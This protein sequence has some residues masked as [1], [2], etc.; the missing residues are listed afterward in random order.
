MAYKPSPDPALDQEPFASMQRLHHASR[1]ALVEAEIV[2]TAVDEARERVEA[3][4]LTFR[5]VLAGGVESADWSATR[6]TATVMNG[7]VR[8][9]EVR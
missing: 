7:V 1:R 3:A 2:G 6:V 5:P 4:G 9:A 8:D